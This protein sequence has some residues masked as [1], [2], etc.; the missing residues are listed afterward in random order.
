[1]VEGQIVPAFLSLI[2]AVGDAE[3]G[4]EE[5]DERGTNEEG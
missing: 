5:E 4:F 2:E 3:I 1:V